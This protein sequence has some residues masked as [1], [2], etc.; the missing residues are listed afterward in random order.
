MSRDKKN[1]TSPAIEGFGQGW[2]S[3]LY[4]QRKKTLRE[5]LGAMVSGNPS[6]YDA[7]L[8]EENSSGIQENSINASM[9]NEFKIKTDSHFP[10]SNVTLDGTPITP[11][12][13]Q[14][15]QEHFVPNTVNSQNEVG[16]SKFDLSYDN[17]PNSKAAEIFNDISSNSFFDQ[18]Q[19]E[20]ITRSTNFK[21]EQKFGHNIVNK[22]IPISHQVSKVL[23]NNRFSPS[24]PDGDPQKIFTNGFVTDSFENYS[25][26]RTNQP[27][28]ESKY[29]T[30]ESAETFAKL[31]A[32][33]TL[34]ASGYVGDDPEDYKYSNKHLGFGDVP[35]P[36]S[37]PNAGIVGIWY[38]AI[39][40]LGA[41]APPDLGGNSEDAKAFTGAQKIKPSEMNPSKDWIYMHQD[42]LRMK[43][44]ISIDWIDSN[45][46]ASNPS[47]VDNDNFATYGTL[48][49]YV[50][51]FGNQKIFGKH[52]IMSVTWMTAIFVQ[53]LVTAASI[54]ALHAVAYGTLLFD[55]PIRENYD[56]QNRGD[57]N[58]NLRQ[59][60]RRGYTIEQ[61]L[62]P[63]DV[64]DI[65]ELL[66]IPDLDELLAGTYLLDLLTDF[67]GIHKPVNTRSLAK[68][69]KPGKEIPIGTFFAYTGAHIIGALQTF[70][71]ALK[72]PWS[73]GFFANLGR[74]IARQNLEWDQQLSGFS[75][76]NEASGFIEFIL[77]LPNSY[78]FK[79]FKTM[80][81][82]GDIAI[83]QF[84][85]IKRNDSQKFFKRDLSSSAIESS[86][87]LPQSFKAAKKLVLSEGTLP[88]LDNP[89][90]FYDESELTKEH[91]DEM[92]KQLDAEYMPFYIRDLRTNE[93][94]SFHAFLDSYSDGWSAAYSDIKGVG[95]VEAASIYSSASRTISFAFTMAAF[96]EKDMNQMYWKLNK[97]VTLLYPQ[98]SKGTEMFAPTSDGTQKRFYMPFSQ[99]PTASPMVRVRI[100]DV[101]T[102][103]YSDLSAMRLMGLGD[104]KTRSG[105]ELNS[106][107]VPLL[108]DP[109]STGLTVGEIPDFTPTVTIGETT[110]LAAQINPNKPMIGDTVELDFNSSQ[111]DKEM[112]DHLIQFATIVKGTK[113]LADI[114]LPV[115]ISNITPTAWAG[116]TLGDIKTVTIKGKHADYKRPEKGKPWKQITRKETIFW[117]TRWKIVGF[118]KDG[119]RVWLSPISQSIPEETK[120]EYLVKKH[121]GIPIFKEND[122][123]LAI[124][125]H[126]LKQGNN[127]LEG[128]IVVSLLYEE[129]T[130]ND[131][132]KSAFTRRTPGGNLI[133]DLN[134]LVGNPVVKSFENNR[135]SGMAG[136]LDNLSIDWQLNTA[137]WE[138]KPGLRA[139]KLIKITCNF[140]PIHDITP[141]L[142]S[143][144]FN[145][146][147]VYKIGDISNSVHSI[148][149]DFEKKIK[150]A[151]KSQSEE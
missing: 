127:K 36:S 32:K 70:I 123:E 15:G 65:M 145:R 79:W 111:A 83:G 148:N 117:D 18:Q 4:P 85:A 95:R 77:K 108:E 55:E 64:N 49:N 5:Y 91:A 72:D 10:I 129:I 80:V 135:G 48:T 92:E 114:N 126:F 89:E 139:P 141:G 62:I 119:V 144:G 38:D 130:K 67:M 140:R 40:Q 146:A 98:Y 116:V 17:D 131:R 51:Q 125:N 150:D 44:N 93:V 47:G 27:L 35:D 7:T 22:T 13:V 26:P 118:S 82:L 107:N 134:F 138:I 128:D 11:Q 29:Y 106:S 102:N 14:D 137:P 84:N 1:N 122:F 142:D 16:N 60:R 33:A 52:H 28:K 96:S 59:G 21:N 73:G 132:Y 105:Q 45:G 34:A 86:Y 87:L 12:R 46:N 9:E 37:G 112:G 94:I 23:L 115:T 66:G 42:K 19:L 124:Q 25:D 54:D 120:K 56:A 58:V 76:S 31:G 81:D 61:D 41:G 68:V 103:N 20:N 90:A 69:G 133:E 100:G 101:L 78:S 6:A 57:I 74:A 147:P 110:V 99:I 39:S 109:P 143:D 24:T 104:K 136:F 50:D 53:S 121:M 151:K 113:Q 30:R 75:E 149:K 63:E 8:T 71:L 43:E 3:D 88:E 2:N 97:L